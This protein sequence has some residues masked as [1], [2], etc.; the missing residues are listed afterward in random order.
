MSRVPTRV[1][2]AAPTALERSVSSRD[3][4]AALFHAYAQHGYSMRQIATHLRCGVTT[5]HRRVR[6]HEADL[7]AGDLL[8]SERNM[9][10]LTRLDPPG[11]ILRAGGTW[12]T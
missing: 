10:D 11:W 7:R 4:I 12:K 2:R 6:A 3:D 5:I 9:E 8:R 1:R